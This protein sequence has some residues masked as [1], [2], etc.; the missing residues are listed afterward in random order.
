[1]TAWRRARPWRPELPLSSLTALHDTT[2]QLAVDIATTGRAG[3]RLDPALSMAVRFS[4]TAAGRL[5][6][7]DA[8]GLIT[9]TL[10]AAFTPQPG[11]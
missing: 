2:R 7:G 10:L 1:M 8:A 4:D 11:G 3:P 9:A 5:E 6:A